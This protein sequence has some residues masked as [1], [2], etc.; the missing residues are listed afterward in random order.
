MTSPQS[1]TKPTPGLT[2]MRESYDRAILNPRLRAVFGPTDAYNLGFWRQEDGN[3][4]TQL[5]QACGRL[6]ERHCSLDPAADAVGCVLDVGCGLGLSTAL[7]NRHYRP[8][9]VYG[10]NLSPHQL[11][12]GRRRHRI[13]GGWIAADALRLPIASGTADRIHCIEAAMHFTPRS[14]FFA[15]AARVLKPG[16][17]LIVTD[18]LAVAASDIVAPANLAGTLDSYLSVAVGQGF[19]PVLAEDVSADTLDPFCRYMQR[20]GLPNV[21][22]YMQSRLSGYVIAVL[23]RRSDIGRGEPS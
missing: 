19:A 20:I 18:V 11:R 5:S 1:Q 4:V 3:P 8:A 2:A 6:I 10:I 21:A 15:E 9:A 14:A 16:G 7:F 13:D 23:Q 22:R 17:R 12:H